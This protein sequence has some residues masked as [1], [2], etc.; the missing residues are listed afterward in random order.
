MSN[1]RDGSELTLKGSSGQERDNQAKG[2]AKGDTKLPKIDFPH[3]GGEWPREW[4]RKA[5]KY[6]Q[7]HQ[8]LDEMK[9]GIAKMYLKGKADI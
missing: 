1:Q 8:I 7:L 9:L 5:R 2:D 4:L 3:F 6:F